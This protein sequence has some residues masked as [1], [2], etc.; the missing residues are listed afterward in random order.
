MSIESADQKSTAGT[1]LGAADSSSEEA[2]AHSLKPVRPPLLRSIIFVTGM[3]EMALQMSASRIVQTHFGSSLLIWANLIGITM[4][5]LAL[6]YFIGG[7]LSDRYPRPGLLYQLTGAIAIWMALVPLIDEPIL[8]LTGGMGLF[9]GSALGIALLFAVPLTLLG[10]VSPFAIRL[11]LSDIQGAGRTAGLVS[12]LSTVGSILGTFLPVLYFLPTI[13]TR[14]TVYLFAGILLIVSAIGLLWT[15]RAPASTLTVAPIKEVTPQPAKRAV[16]DSEAQPVGMSFLLPIVFICGMAVMTTEM[17]ASRLV[18]P[19]FGDSQLIWACV[20]GFI[21]IYLAIG[22]FLGGRLG[23][24][25]PRPSFLYQLTGLAALVMGLIPIASTPILTLSSEGFKN[26]DGVIFFG[27]LLGIIFLFAIPVILLGCVSPFAIRLFMRNLNDAGRTAGR[28]SSIS[29]IGSILGTF[30][31]VLVFIPTV[32]TRN[33]L[34]IFSIVLLLVSTAG[35]FQTRSNRMPVFAG[36]TV[37]VALLAV[38]ITF[39]IKAAPYGTLLV[40]KESAYNYIQVVKLDNGQINLVLN[41]GHAVHSIY[42]PN[43]VLTGGPWDYYMV[44]PFF[45]K[46]ITEKDVK[47][48]LLLGL[49]AGT[50]PKQLTKA[51]G[52][53]IHIDGVEIDPEIISLGRQYFDMN[54]P[55][56]NAIAEDGRY[57]LNNSNQKYDI[58]GVDA[59]KQPY[60]PF[61]MTTKEFFQQARDHLNPNGVVVINAGTPGVNNKIDYRLADALAQTM[62]QVYPNVYMIDLYTV[63]GYFNT[64]VV[65]TNQP[66]TLANF[67]NNMSQVVTNDLIKQVGTGALTKNSIKEW[68]GVSED[69]TVPP[70][71]TDDLAPVERLIDQVIIDYV[72]SGGK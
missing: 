26:A 58:I 14:L 8:D 38:F 71:F 46:G 35:L 21:I 37:V 18:Q 20:I 70:V 36:L 15:R 32:G 59:Y 31:P 5:C 64:M 53:Q 17:C 24:R 9:V 63:A 45:N 7:R 72:V 6:G 34:Y 23:D 66:T 16:A 54:E 62:K 11:L 43:Q 2:I 69:G 42:N 51:Y 41:E 10:C 1:G 67:Q 61:H 49:G 4:I 52:S 25:F 33:T 47:S 60:I 12:S 56:L 22:Y 13:G 27:S 19:Y 40:E 48:A 44:T 50:V 3:S 57:A 39:S 65:A 55:N 30:L 68:T 29:T 28:V